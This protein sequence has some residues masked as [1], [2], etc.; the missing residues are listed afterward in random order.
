MQEP[1]PVSWMTDDLTLSSS[2]VH[3]RVVSDTG[4]GP[5]QRCQRCD[6]LLGSHI[7]PNPLCGEQHGQSAG[8]LCAWCR[9]SLQESMNVIDFACLHD[10]ELEVL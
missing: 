5:V 10:L 7:C 3:L 4:G 8:N 9:Q 1:V 2:P 6:I